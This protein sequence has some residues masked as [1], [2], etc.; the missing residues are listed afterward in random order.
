MNELNSLLFEL[1]NIRSVASDTIFHF[2]KVIGGYIIGLIEKEHSKL[3]QFCNAYVCNI[4]KN[5]LKDTNEA[6]KSLNSLRNSLSKVTNSLGI[7]AE[8]VTAYYTF[9]DKYEKCKNKD[10]DAFLNSIV[11]TGANV[12]T[13][14]A[15]S[16]AGSVL[17]SF[18]P[19]PFV[20]TI[21]GAITGSLIGSFVNSLYDLEC[22]FNFF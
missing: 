14:M 9:K 8:S 2:D 16:Y 12:G 4:P 7:V 6:I 20:G 18:I 11:Q 1:K 10:V 13:N 15:F 5:V 21:A 19:I 3:K 17:G 22:W